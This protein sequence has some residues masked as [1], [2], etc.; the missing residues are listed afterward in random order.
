MK[1]VT[2]K[3]GNDS[4][5]DKWY[6]LSYSDICNT[7]Y[8]FDADAS[9][10]SKSRCAQKA[11][12]AITMTER[13]FGDKND[14]G[15]W[16]CTSD[17]SNAK[18]VQNDGSTAD[19]KT[20]SNKGV[21]PVVNVKLSVASTLKK[22]RMNHIIRLLLSSNCQ[23]TLS[24]IKFRIKGLKPVNSLLSLDPNKK[25]NTFIWHMAKRGCHF[26]TAPFIPQIYTRN[27]TSAIASRGRSASSRRNG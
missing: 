25:L 27:H 24:D 12:F 11:G 21:R 15:W 8:G 23:K 3:S 7:A 17:G 16:L 2:V 22:A 1:L 10:T 26:P 9:I 13:T 20:T 14:N 19:Q 4:T 18:V 6:I 5:Q